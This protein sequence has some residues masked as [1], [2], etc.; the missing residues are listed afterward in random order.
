MLHNIFSKKN[1]NNVLILWQL[2]RNSTLKKQFRKVSKNAI[3]KTIYERNLLSPCP[4]G[5]KSK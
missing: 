2:N 5:Q 3:K 4:D 1:K